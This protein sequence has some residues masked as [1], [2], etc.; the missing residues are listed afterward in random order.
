MN[1]I[2]PYVREIYNSCYFFIYDDALSKNVVS[3]FVRNKHKTHL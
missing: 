1:Y 2:F 3:L